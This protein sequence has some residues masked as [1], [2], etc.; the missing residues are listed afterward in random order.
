MR[1][2]EEPE[3]I[4]TAAAIGAL[5][6]RVR[7]TTV[8]ALFVVAAAVILLS[9]EPFAESLIGAGTELGIDR[10]LLVQA[11]AVAG[12]AG[13]R[14]S[15]VRHRDPVRRPRQG[16]RRDCDA[17]LLEGQPV[18]AVGGV[19]AGGLHDRRRRHR[20]AARRPP[21]GGSLADRDAGWR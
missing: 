20:L 2:V 1:D 10:F 7:R 14:G 5:P 8:L 16:H 9:A 13:L 6:D 11:G 18:D 19:T 17:D 3:L 4:G 12:A 15:R 21:V